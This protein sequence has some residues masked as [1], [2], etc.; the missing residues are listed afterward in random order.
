MWFV[1]AHV[2]DV[3]AG[4]VLRGRAVETAPDGTVVQV[5]AAP[6]PA[7]P[8]AVDVAGRWLLPGHNRRSLS[9]DSSAVG[10]QTSQQA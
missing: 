3:L 10:L 4:E 9:S 6:P 2:V 8:D 7:V 5:A 1:N